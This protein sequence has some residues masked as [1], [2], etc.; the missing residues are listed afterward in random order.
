MKIEIPHKVKKIIHILF[1][2]GY[3]AYIVGGC[4]RDSILGKKP[5]DWDIATSAK[6]DQVKALFKRTV[7]TGIKHGTVTVLFGK[8]GFEVT[9]FRIDGEYE[10]NRRPKDVIFTSSLEEDLKRRDFT[11]NAMAYN[12]RTGLIDLFGGQKDMK[13]GFICCVGN[14]VQRF[15]EDALRM[16]RAVRF[17]GQFGY[18]IQKDT[19]KAIGQYAGD[20]N[21]ISMERISTELQ[22]L[23]LSPHPEKIEDAYRMGMTNVFL[24]EF[25]AMM[26]TRQSHP[27]HLYT[28]GE[29][30]IR[31][32]C[33]VPN[34]KIERLAM[35]FCHIGKP[36]SKTM[37]KDGIVHFH[38]YE[39]LGEKITSQVMRRLRYDNESI[40]KVS[41]LVRWHNYCPELI[42]KEVRK[43]IYKIGEDI[44]PFLFSIKRGDILAKGQSV[45]KE[46]LLYVDRLQDIYE[47]IINNKDCISRKTLAIS[48]K[49]LIE[50]GVP[51][52]KE[53]G[54][55]LEELLNH[56]LENPQLNEK[57]QLLN[58][59]S[60]LR[61]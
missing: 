46:K 32:L 16:M 2:S 23:L 21:K 13:N 33:Y 17:S 56:V 40:N 34:N 1:E 29:Y 43:G 9:T 47:D 57:E 4:V 39:E 51:E 18:E 49:D 19:K 53:M 44:F 48:G 50:A 28:V 3:E 36:L 15:K 42:K 52:G 10:D 35:F 11:M 61:T 8:E 55:I 20:L 22:K 6:P 12:D 7:D 27:Y 45:Q 31:S 24:P 30:T 60:T 59:L 14:P 38:N 5:K 26:D 37:D 41:R 54:N 58:I 25:D